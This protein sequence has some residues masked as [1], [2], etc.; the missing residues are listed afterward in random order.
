MAKRH[1][2]ICSRSLVIK[3]R[4]VK[5]IMRYYYIPRKITKIKQTDNTKY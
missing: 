3:K 2:K 4:Q 5:I 1:M